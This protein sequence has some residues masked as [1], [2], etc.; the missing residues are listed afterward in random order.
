MNLQGKKLG[1]NRQLLAEELS[2]SQAGQVLDKEFFK[3][4]ARHLRRTTTF[5][6]V[7]IWKQLNNEYGS[8]GF[9]YSPR[10][11]GYWIEGIA[12]NSESESLD[13]DFLNVDPIN[14]PYLSQL[15]LLK[16]SVLRGKG[17]T[18]IESETAVKLRYFFNNPN[19][20][21]VDLFPQLAVINAYARTSEA[22]M[23]LDHLKSLLAYQPWNPSGARLYCEALDEER[24]RLPSIPMLTMISFDDHYSFDPPKYIV[25]AYAHLRIPALSYFN[26]TEGRLRTPNLNVEHYDSTST[27]DPNYPESFQFDELAQYCNWRD[28]ITRFNNGT[29]EPLLSFPLLPKEFFDDDR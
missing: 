14:A 29:L 7:R 17:L 11:V 20:N 5:G 26:M 19:G 3:A 2:S 12:A 1:N 8:V 28:L 22:G 4:E 23:P 10:A 25:G 24:I 15:D 9:D 16:R 18:A 21:S 6:A 13:F 27:P